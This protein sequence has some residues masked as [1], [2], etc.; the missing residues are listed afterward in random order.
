M[1]EYENQQCGTCRYWQHDGNMSVIVGQPKRGICR[2][3]PPHAT[4]LPTNQGP[5]IISSYPSLPDNFQACSRHEVRS[6][7]EA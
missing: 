5:Q 2:V 6:L 1:N 7:I 3:D 4:S